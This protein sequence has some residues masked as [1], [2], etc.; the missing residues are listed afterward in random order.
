MW[1]EAMARSNRKL[2]ALAVKALAKGDGRFGDGG[3]LY[4]QARGGK[5]SWLFRYMLDGKAREMGLGAYPAVTLEAA[6]AA[7]A[8]QRRV[9]AKKIDPLSAREAEN[10]AKKRAAAVETAKRKTFADCADAYIAAHRAG[11][12][13]TKH[14]AQWASTLSTYAGPVFGALPVGEVDTAL[15][16]RVLEP[17]WTTKPETASRL[18]GRIEAVLDWA[19]ARELRT[20]ANPARW[21]GHLDHLLPARAKVARVKHHA[22]L[23]WREIGPFMTRLRAVDGAGARALEFAVL[24]A[25]RSGEVIGATWDEIDLPART[26]TVPAER[27][28]AAR[29]HR[30]PLSDA[31]VVVLAALPRTD[32]PWVFPGGRAGKPLSNMAMAMVLRRLDRADLTVHGFRS[33][34][35]DWAGESTGYPRDV[36]EMA[37]AHAVGGVEGAYRRGD[38]FEKRRRLMA[39]W[40]AW[41]ARADAGSVTPLRAREH[42]AA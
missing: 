36:C 12:R 41:C 20:G 2:T 11:W 26:W 32:A 3:G 23:D 14:A 6:R 33:T 34:F 10:E 1:A 39:D 8:E 19:T 13:N 15:V 35:R 22:A 25:A 40:A 24:T 27:M 16:L 28:K 4:L 42:D 17:L 30:V 29:E 38:L 7:A 37:L 31:A 9:L 18:R 5:A 21:R